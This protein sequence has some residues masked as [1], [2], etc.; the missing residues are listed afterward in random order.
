[1][2]VIMMI[3]KITLLRMNDNYHDDSCNNNNND[4]NKEYLRIFNKTFL[5]LN[6]LSSQ[7]TRNCMAR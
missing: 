6:L 7:K 3:M 2:F 1:M 5:I 4:I